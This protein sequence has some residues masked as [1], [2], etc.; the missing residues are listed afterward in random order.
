VSLAIGVKKI[1]V[2]GLFGTPSSDLTFT[3]GGDAIFNVILG[4]PNS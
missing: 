4:A 3:N 2:I 1:V